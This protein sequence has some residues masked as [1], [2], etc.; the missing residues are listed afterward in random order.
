MDKKKTIHAILNATCKLMPS[1]IEG[2]GVFAI[3]DIPKGVNPFADELPSRWVKL[4]KSD[5]AEADEEVKKL[6]KAFFVEE[7]E[8]IWVNKDGFYSMG[9]SFY[10]NHS[11]NSNL[12]ALDTKNG[13]V[14]FTKRKILKGEE[15]L[16]DY[17]EFEE[18]QHEYM[19]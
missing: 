12:R 1:K 6:V 14:F 17:D 5:L 3:K 11:K 8:Y 7:G 4:K 15:L 10:T 18:E 9:L 13:T 2:I 19:K 16:S